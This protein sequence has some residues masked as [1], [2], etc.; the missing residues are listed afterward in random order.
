MSVESL[1]STVRKKSEQKQSAAREEVK[2]LTRFLMPL[3]LAGV[4]VFGIGCGT[5]ITGGR[6]HLDK[7]KIELKT[8][9]LNKISNLSLESAYNSPDERR[10]FLID[11]NIENGLAW[12]ILKFSVD[13]KQYKISSPVEVAADETLILGYDESKNGLFGKEELGQRNSIT[14]SYLT[15]D[16]DDGILIRVSTTSNGVLQELVK[17]DGGVATGKYATFLSPTADEQQNNSDLKP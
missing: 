2:H 3:V 16:A 12:V 1:S 4:S 6:Q 14:I 13:D 11:Q 5:N 8:S 7:S 10:R 9:E 17:L 15:K